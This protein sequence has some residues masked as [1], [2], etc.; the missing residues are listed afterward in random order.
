[1][2]NIPWV[3]I[4]KHFKGLIT[5][6]DQEELDGWVKCAAE[7]KLLL[8]E[9]ESDIKKGLPYPGDFYSD[10]PSTWQKIKS[11]IDVPLRSGFSR[12][13]MYRAVAAVAI[14]LLIV[15]LA[16]GW[17]WQKKVQYNADSTAYTI[18]ISPKGQRT[19]VV[20]PDKSKVWLN[21]NTTI[22][23]PSNFNQKERR[24]YIDGEAFFDVT[25]NLSKP[26]IVSTSSFNIK[27]Y[28]TTFNVTAYKGDKTIETT[29]VKGK[30]SITGL[31]IKGKKEGE[32]IL[33]PNESFKLIKN[34]K[35]A[36]NESKKELN[37]LSSTGTN[38]NK[39]LNDEAIEPQLPQI[40]VTQNV[41]VA[42]IIAWKEGKLIFDN[43]TFE[44]LSAKFERRYDVKIYFV[45]KKVANLKYSGVFEKENINQA[46]D[47]MKLTTP[48]EYKMNLKEVYISDKK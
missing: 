12:K 1:M 38:L 24:V 48:F 3:L 46:L 18:I 29:L 34:E 10:K 9:I 40:I 16:G 14:P 47:A 17:Y 2:R 30:I 25:H 42:S 35:L 44:S 28:G 33:M 19:Q 8:Q 41:K 32:I 15:G 7:N 22:K 45:D 4:D 39:T 20:L 21:S 5:D 31:Q 23:Y 6:K 13:Q 27:V 43:E 36:D 37:N 11:R 26:F